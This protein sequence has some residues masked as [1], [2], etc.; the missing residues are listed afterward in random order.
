MALLRFASFFLLSVC[1]F[2][3]YFLLLDIG[4]QEFRSVGS[5]TKQGREVA[6]R[7]PVGWALQPVAHLARFIKA[8]GAWLWSI[9]QEGLFRRE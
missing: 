6:T 9:L 1:V 7:A 4:I 8:A 3:L 2:I 5:R